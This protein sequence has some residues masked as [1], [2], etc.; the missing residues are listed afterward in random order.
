VLGSSSSS[1]GGR[2]GQAGAEVEPAAHAARVGRDAA[3]GG[4]VEPEA[5]EHVGGAG[6]R[7]GGRQAV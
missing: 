3:V 2:P 7:L 6:A 1:T 5:L 4:L